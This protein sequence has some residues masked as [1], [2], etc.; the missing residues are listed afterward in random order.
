MAM[1]MTMIMMMIV[2]LDSE[3][4]DDAD[5]DDDDDNDD[6]HVDADRTDDTGHATRIKNTDKANRRRV[7]GLRTSKVQVCIDP[8]AQ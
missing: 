8:G 1:T 4:D 2:M 7:I 6:V 5:D 3:E